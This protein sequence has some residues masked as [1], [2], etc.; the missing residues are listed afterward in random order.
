MTPTKPKFNTKKITRST[1][2][3]FL[4]VFIDPNDEI[5]GLVLVERIS[6]RKFLE[7]TILAADVPQ[8][9]FER[10]HADSCRRVE[11]H[12]PLLLSLLNT[13]KNDA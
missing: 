2:P 6:E 12:N 11:G 1:K 7:G 8:V 13:A 3:P 10:L 9:M 4:A 5:R